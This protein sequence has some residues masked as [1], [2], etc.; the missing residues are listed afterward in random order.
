MAEETGSLIAQRVVFFYVRSL[1]EATLRK[2]AKPGEKPMFSVTSLVAHEDVQTD[3]FKGL[4]KA[5]DEAAI[6]RFGAKG[7]EEMLDE[8]RFESPFRKDVGSKGFDKTRFKFLISSSS[9]ESF[10]PVIRRRDG[11]V[12]TI[13]D[14]REVW[15]GIT[16]RI[17]LSP[18]AYG[19]LN[20]TWT[21]GVKLD[22]RNVQILKST[23]L[24]KRAGGDG[25]ELG[26]LPDDPEDE[27]PAVG[28]M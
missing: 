22:L 20:T 3:W 17:S 27:G 6:A 21:P 23:P 7:Y 10:P 5:V 25:S 13:A 26:A 18:R 14:K 4:Q 19:G 28:E 8:G 11:T 24:M 2:G 15:D 16:G 9:G 1:L 12:I